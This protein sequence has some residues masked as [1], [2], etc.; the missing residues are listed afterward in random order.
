MQK[1]AT[2]STWIAN[3]LVLVAYLVSWENWTS[4]KKKLSK[5]HLPYVLIFPILCTSTEISFSKYL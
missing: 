1:V 2:T 3:H 4:W 5:T